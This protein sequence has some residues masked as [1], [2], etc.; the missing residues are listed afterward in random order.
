MPE[1]S[2][3]YA[4]VLDAGLPKAL[5][6]VVEEIRRLG[7]IAPRKISGLADGLG[8]L[9]YVYA[10][11]MLVVAAERIAASGYAYGFIGRAP[12][13]PELGE[14]VYLLAMSQCHIVA[15]ALLAPLGIHLYI[16]RAAEASLHAERLRL[17]YTRAHFM[18]HHGV[19]LG[20]TEERRGFPHFLAVFPVAA[21][22][23]VCIYTWLLVG[24][25]TE[26]VVNAGLSGVSLYYGDIFSV[27][28]TDPELHTLLAA[29]SIAALLSTAYTVAVH[30][31]LDAASATRLS[32]YAALPPVLAAVAIYFNTDVLAYTALLAEMMLI[33]RYSIALY[34]AATRIR[35]EAGEKAE[36]LLKIIREKA[37]KRRKS[38]VKD[39]G[40]ESCR[41]AECAGREQSTG[42]HGQTPG[43]AGDTT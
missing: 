37:E 40:E 17:L 1:D 27:A 26:Y 30:R 23:A 31:V 9:F 15:A 21:S 6:G 7:R 16:R 24:R 19:E 32:R 10:A 33:H 18:I 12:E 35:H 43:S 29:A 11:I 28:Y 25:A 8:V 22:V 5:I 2:S 34:T 41:G 39:G 20:E 4:D 13:P 36:A 3:L 14:A 42:S 38:L